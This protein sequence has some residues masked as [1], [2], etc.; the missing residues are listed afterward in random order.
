VDVEGFITRLAA[1]HRQLAKV[2]L[3]NEFI[4]YKEGEQENDHAKQVTLHAAIIQQHRFRAL[5]KIS[6]SSGTV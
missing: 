4:T 2:E 3:Q 5:P 6:A 1:A